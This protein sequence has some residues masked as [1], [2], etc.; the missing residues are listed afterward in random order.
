M[1]SIRER[2]LQ[3]LMAMFQSVA[4][5]QGATLIRSPTTPLTREQ[6]PALL[7]IAESDQVS[8]RPND[9]VERQLVLRL[10]ALARDQVDGAGQTIDANVIA[11]GLLAASH[12]ALFANKTLDGLAIGLQEL[13][14]DWQ[15]EDADADLAAM[16]ARYQITYRT[17]AADISQ[18]G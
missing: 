13:D 10:T 14:C 16:P 7:L 6:S 12:L 17:L 5:N 9:R 1:T 15:E 2:I 4:S 3:T 8:A 18:L 11:D